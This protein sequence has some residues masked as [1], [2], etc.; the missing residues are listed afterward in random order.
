MHIFGAHQEKEGKEMASS[1]K[2]K[3]NPVQAP[4][5]NPAPSSAHAQRLQVQQVQGQP[6][7]TYLTGTRFEEA[8]GATRPADSDMLPFTRSPVAELTDDNT[9]A[10]Y[11]SESQPADGLRPTLAD[12]VIEH[13][14]QARL[15]R[16][17]PH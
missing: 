10:F 7:N 14:R 11:P 9:F 3:T 4:I 17:R 15:R 8:E 2:R 16:Q 6:G 5:G 1:E 13:L 12:L